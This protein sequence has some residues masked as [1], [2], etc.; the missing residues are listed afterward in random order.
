M[1]LGSK[2][3]LWVSFACYDVTR[4]R[5]SLTKSGLSAGMP[6]PL[7]SRARTVTGLP[8]T[9]KRP[10]VSVADLIPGGGHGLSAMVDQA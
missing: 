10:N 6:I 2:L 8:Y 5:I 1:N 4:R 7:F 3:D 9:I